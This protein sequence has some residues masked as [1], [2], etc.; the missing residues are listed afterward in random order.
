MARLTELADEDVGVIVRIRTTA[1]H[2]DLPRRRAGRGPFG[3]EWQTLAV[4]VAELKQLSDDP[5]LVVEE[6][7]ELPPAATETPAPEKTPAGRKK[8]TR[9]DGHPTRHPKTA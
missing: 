3:R 5:A 7:D 8:G 6:C 4:S 1:T 9:T 2:G